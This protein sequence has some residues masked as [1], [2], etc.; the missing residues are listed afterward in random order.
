MLNVKVVFF[1]FFLSASPGFNFHK[2]P[3]SVLFQKVNNEKIDEIVS[4]LEDDDGYVVDFNVDTLTFT[5]FSLQY[6]CF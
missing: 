2:E 6:K 1:H 5:V 3:T 4:Y